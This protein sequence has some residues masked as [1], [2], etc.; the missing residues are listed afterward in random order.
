MHEGQLA[1]GA[2]TAHEAAGHRHVVAFPFLKQGSDLSG[3]VSWVGAGRIRV[4]ARSAQLLERV[5]ARLEFV[6]L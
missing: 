6:G 3:R 4:D 2:Q 5:E 1:H